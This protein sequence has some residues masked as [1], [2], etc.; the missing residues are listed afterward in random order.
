M[1]ISIHI[2]AVLFTGR[3]TTL[4]W[5]TSS[6]CRAFTTRLCCCCCS[7]ID[8]DQR[9]SK[10]TYKSKVSKMYINFRGWQMVLKDL[11]LK[12]GTIWSEGN[13]LVQ[14]WQRF[15]NGQSLTKVT[16]WS[17]FG[18]G[19]LNFLIWQR[20]PKCP[21]LAKGNYSPKLARVPK[22]PSLTKGP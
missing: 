18:K 7:W 10:G 3:L 12:E 21:R 13:L 22:G 8:I 4:W 15:T 1:N 9:Y 17:K 11:R 5:L 14:V 19:G 2:N 16:V 6:S 20:V